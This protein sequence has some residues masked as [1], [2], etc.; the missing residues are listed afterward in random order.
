[1]KGTAGQK[2]KLKIA[3]KERTTS[4]IYSIVLRGITYTLESLFRDYYVSENIEALMNYVNSRNTMEAHEY[5]KLLSEAKDFYPV[6]ICA[7]FVN[8]LKRHTKNFKLNELEAEKK[9]KLSEELYN[10][11]FEFFIDWLCVVDIDPLLFYRLAAAYKKKFDMQMYITKQIRYQL[12]E[13][14]E[15]ILRLQLVEIITVYLIEQVAIHLGLAGLDFIDYYKYSCEDK[16]D[17]EH[18]V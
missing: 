9:R 17:N 6:L 11:L 3:G 2:R 18:I 1:M 5:K 7:I 16:S 4:E 15:R 10:E 12:T 13:M 14:E 8:P